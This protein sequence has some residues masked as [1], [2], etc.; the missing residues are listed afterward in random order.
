[1]QVEISIREDIDALAEIA[2]KYKV[3]VIDLVISYFN[4]KRIIPLIEADAMKERSK[5]DVKI[6]AEDMEII[7]QL[8]ASN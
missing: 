5:A 4:Q 6:Q 1:M 3:S 7:G 2:T 8:F